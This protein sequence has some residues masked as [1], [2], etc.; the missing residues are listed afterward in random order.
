MSDL[1][2]VLSESASYYLEERAKVAARLALLPKGT[3][4]K[5]KIG[6]K[7]YYY[8]SY[9]QGKKIVDQ[10]LGAAAPE[11]LQRR[12]EER[13]TLLHRLKEIKASLALLRH[14][15]E[16]ASDLND[17]VVEILRTFSKEGLWDSGLEIIGSWCFLIY[18]KHLRLERYPLRTQDIDLLI[19]FPYKGNRHDLPSILKRLGF[20]ESFHPDGSSLFSGGGLR[21]EFVSPKRGRTE[22]SAARVPGLK[23]TSQLLRYT[24]LLTSQTMVLNVAQG[25]KVR[26]PSPAAFLLHKLIIA[27][28]WQRLEKQE[29]DLRQGITIARFVLQNLEH[30][31]QLSALWSGLLPGWRKKAAHSLRKARELLPLEIGIADSLAELL[32]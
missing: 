5:K 12:L 31:R 32:G 3:I 2:N 8:L 9:R 21:I 30:R 11:D 15:A 28:L 14:P 29:K 16:A 26:L 27:T 7:P 19:P 25:A 4:K 20:A 13:K 22:A 10:Y 1:R 17:A 18:Q 23:V 24:D 6:G